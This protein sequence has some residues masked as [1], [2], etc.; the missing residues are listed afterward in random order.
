MKPRKRVYKIPQGQD[1]RRT[2]SAINTILGGVYEGTRFLKLS[3]DEMDTIETQKKELRESRRRHSLN[4]GQSSSD[5]SF[6]R[7]F[8]ADAKQKDE[9]FTFQKSI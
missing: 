4:S 6:D 2:K 1:L 3:K 8:N 9:K 5:D 7:D